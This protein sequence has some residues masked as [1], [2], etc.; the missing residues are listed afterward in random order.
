MV[1]SANYSDEKLLGA[2][3]FVDQHIQVGCQET[4]PPQQHNGFSCSESSTK[5]EMMGQILLALLTLSL[6]FLPDI[7]FALLPMGQLSLT[8]LLFPMACPT[9]LTF[10]SQSEEVRH[11]LALLPFPRQENTSEAGF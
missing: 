10:K 11:V 9:P 2:L 4:H 1:V 7:H 8:M 3:G 5:H 6:F